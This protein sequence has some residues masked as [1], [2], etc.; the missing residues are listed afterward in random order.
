VATAECVCAV[1][2]PGC[3]GPPARQRL[4]PVQPFPRVGHASGVDVHGGHRVRSKAVGK[5]AGCPSGSCPALQL[6]ELGQQGVVVVG[7]AKPFLP[8][9]AIGGVEGLTAEVVGQGEPWCEQV[10]GNGL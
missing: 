3:G 8:V 1:A 5:Q 7:R 9:G 2:D 4:E 10:P 6:V